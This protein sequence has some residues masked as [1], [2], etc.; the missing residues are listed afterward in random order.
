MIIKSDKS[1]YYVTEFILDDIENNV[2]V[3]RGFKNI[4]TLNKISIRKVKLKKQFI[5]S[6]IDLKKTI[7]FIGNKD[8]NIMR[9]NTISQLVELNKNGI[10]YLPYNF[11]EVNKLYN[12]MT[13]K[14]TELN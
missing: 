1:T 2:M 6:I 7:V 12:K 13:K 14:V 9:L 5:W 3:F 10:E 11:K 4:S 8:E